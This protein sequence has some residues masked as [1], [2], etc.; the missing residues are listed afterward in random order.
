MRIFALNSYLLRD[1]TE[2]IR[3]IDFKKKK[4]NK[5]ENVISMKE[6]TNQIILYLKEIEFFLKANVIFLQQDIIF[7]S[8][9]THKKHH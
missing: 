3:I 2:R 7:D 4:K 6:T 8:F 5:D 9:A 1:K